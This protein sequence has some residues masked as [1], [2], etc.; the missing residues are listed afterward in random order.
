VA[1][2]SADPTARLRQLVGGPRGVVEGGLPP[3][4][5]VVTNAAVSATA[6]SGRGL[7]PA[8]VAAVGT[9][10]VLAL[11]AV[12]QRRPLQQA[13]AGLTAVALAA[14]YAAWADDAR[15]YFLPGI[16]VDAAYALALTGSVLAGRPLI[17]TVHDWLFTHDHRRW[18]EDMRLRRVVVV[19]TLGWAGVYAVRA[20]V[21]AALYASDQPELLAVTK[22]GLG[23]PLTLAAAA[24][25]LAWLRHVKDS[26][27][28]P[29]RERA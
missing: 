4:T 2:P 22:L 1:E 9:G 18:R 5:F 25:S 23:W 11:V 10:F 16:W 13:L 7:T 20:S 28:P 8:I 15:A 17:G 21:Q 14:G 26:T 12:V 6:G 27:R 29:V 19:L 24:V 3:V